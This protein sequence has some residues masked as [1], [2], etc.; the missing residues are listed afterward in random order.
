ME[1]IKSNVGLVGVKTNHFWVG[2]TNQLSVRVRVRV[3]VGSRV[4]DARDVYV[5]PMGGCICASARQHT[6]L[7]HNP[8]MLAPYVKATDCITVVVS[9]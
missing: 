8:P 1:Q 4:C 6:S 9:L 5:M 3:R 2:E 7:V